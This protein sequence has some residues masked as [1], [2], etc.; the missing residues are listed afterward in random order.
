MSV[1]YHLVPVD[2]E[3]ESFVDLNWSQLQLNNE[4]SSF[5]ELMM[6]Y[7]DRFLFYFDKHE[8]FFDFI[9]S[10]NQSEIS[11]ITYQPEHLKSLFLE[12]LEIL[13]TK[14]DFPIPYF[15]Y[16]KY[17]DQL[18]STFLYVNLRGEELNKLVED[19]I[20]FKDG[21]FDVQI[22]FD[23][24]NNY[25]ELRGEFRQKPTLVYI[26]MEEGERFRSNLDLTAFPGIV[27]I[28]GTLKNIRLGREIKQVSLLLKSPYEHLAPMFRNLI[29][30]CS[31]CIE[32]NYS[33]KSFISC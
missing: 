26:K 4:F 11:K 29:D 14:E 25:A 16:F 27:N 20:Y 21:A 32:N 15:H 9:F 8:L 24:W 30:T 6:N 23:K 7:P 10:L 17:E 22:S 31:Y 2:K 18:E 3:T 12:L 5:A 19:K 33:I 28:N 1:S 13:E